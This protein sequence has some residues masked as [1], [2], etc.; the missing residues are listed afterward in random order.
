MIVSEI[1]V[2]LDHNLNFQ[3]SFYP[4]TFV[5]NR[6]V[7]NK[8]KKSEW[9]VREFKEISIALCTRILSRYLPT[10]I[11]IH[12]LIYRCRFVNVWAPNPCTH[13]LWRIIIFCLLATHQLC[14]LYFH[15]LYY[16]CYFLPLSFTSYCHLWVCQ[17]SFFRNS[18][19][20]GQHSFLPSP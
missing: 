2:R 20:H 6:F 14:K 16:R 7:W 12:K 13:F 19:K 4:G 10:H 8:E 9:Y 18:W 5:F 11:C 17:E 15:S 1:L 3:T